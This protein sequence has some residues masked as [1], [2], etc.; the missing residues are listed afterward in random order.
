MSKLGLDM[1]LGLLLL[2]LNFFER[3]GLQCL[4][5]GD[6]PERRYRYCKLGYI[7]HSIYEIAVLLEEKP[8][9]SLQVKAGSARAE[10]CS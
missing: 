4:L 3:H 9:I 10:S 6:L 5:R 1:L 2:E 8:I 7:S